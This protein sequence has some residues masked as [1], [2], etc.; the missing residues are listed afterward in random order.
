MTLLLVGDSEA[1]GRLLEPLSG[2]GIEATLDEHPPAVEKG[3]I[4]RLADEMLRLEEALE[5]HRPAA[6]LL[7]DASDR[8]LAAA[9][10]ATKLLI[11]VA[12][13]GLDRTDGAN[14]RLLAQLADRKLT[15][16][17]GEILAWTEA[18][19]RLSGL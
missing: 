3:E 1:T 16:E 17:P 5:A 11:P 7:A 2:A 12:T 9:L 13:V 18:L 4:A 10:V 8:A 15:A 6:V 14:E 19:P